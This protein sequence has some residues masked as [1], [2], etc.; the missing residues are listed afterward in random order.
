MN[1]GYKYKKNTIKENL[2][3]QILDNAEFEKTK[4]REWNKMKVNFN[5]IKAKNLFLRMVWKIKAHRQHL[6]SI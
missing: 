4:M 1:K 2:S 5:Y 3:L 6:Q